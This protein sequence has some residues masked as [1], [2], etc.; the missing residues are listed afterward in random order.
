MKR[1]RENRLTVVEVGLVKAMLA[2]GV[3]NDQAILAYFT[4]PGRTVN[5]ARVSEIR[6]GHA[7]P[8]PKIG[9]LGEVACDHVE[10]RP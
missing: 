10:Q 2:E 1:S 7:Q 6:E 9:L 3:L 5:Y 8:T 4:R